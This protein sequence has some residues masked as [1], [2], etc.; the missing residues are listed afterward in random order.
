MIAPVSSVLCVLLFIVFLAVAGC[1]YFLPTDP[2]DAMGGTSESESTDDSGQVGSESVPDPD[3][4]VD[5]IISQ[6]VE[7]KLSPEV[8]QENIT[9]ETNVTVDLVFSGSFDLQPDLGLC[10]HLAD[11]FSCDKYDVR[12][13][14]FGEIVGRN[15]YYPDLINCRDGNTEKG[16]NPQNKYCIIQECQP[17]DENNI[18]YA[19]GGPTIYAEYGYRVEKV[20]NGILTHYTLRR[21]GEM[22][23]EFDSEFDCTVY[24]AELDG[25][26]VN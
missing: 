1:A 19:Y 17:L 7:E 2:A 13:C 20:A 22:H 12:R 26:W 16:E 8:V 24:K 11:S 3:A 9:N 25:L 5:D 21:C 18:V 23:K 10:P 6:V 14:D 15:D 4:A